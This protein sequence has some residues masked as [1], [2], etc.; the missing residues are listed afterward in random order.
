MPSAAPSRLA[1]RFFEAYGNGDLGAVRSV[2][3][4]DL[5][6]YV[7]NADGGVDLVEGRDHYMER[8]PDLRAAGGRLDL[9]QTIEI[10]A[11]QVL[12]MVEI[13]A[14]RNDRTLH[15]FASFLARIRDGRVTHLWMVEAHPAYSDEF[16][17][18]S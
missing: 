5:V 3:A 9:T 15:N 17:H 7:T 14:R 6:A 16:W 1:R 18:A 11:Q 10:D 12:A 2:L 8:L 4:D 13:R